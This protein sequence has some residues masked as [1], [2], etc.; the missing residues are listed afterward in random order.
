MKNCYIFLILLISLLTFTIKGVSVRDNM[1]D[2]GPKGKDADH[3]TPTTL[4]DG[5]KKVSIYP[6]AQYNF[7]KLYGSQWARQF[8]D[9]IFISGFTPYG[10]EN[11]IILK[12]LPN[13][14]TN[15]NAA[16]FPLRASGKLKTSGDV[17]DKNPFWKI[18]LTDNHTVEITSL[19]TVKNLI[20][21]KNARY[22]GLSKWRKTEKTNQESY[23]CGEKGA[24]IIVKCSPESETG[25]FPL[26]LFLNGKKIYEK[27]LSGGTHTIKLENKITGDIGKYKLKAKWRNAKCEREDYWFL[28]KWGTRL[29]IEGEEFDL[30]KFLDEYQFFEKTTFILERFDMLPSAIKNLKPNN[31]KLNLGKEK[32]LAQNVWCDHD[33]PVHDHEKSNEKRLCEYAFSTL[34]YKGSALI[35]Y[36][37]NYDLASFTAG[38]FLSKIPFLEQLSNKVKLI[39]NYDIIGELND[40]IAEEIKKESGLDTTGQVT[41]GGNAFVKH[42]EHLYYYPC[43]KFE[44]FLVNNQENK[45]FTGRIYVK[46]K[47]KVVV[48]VNLS[49]FW[50]KTFNNKTY[51]QWLMTAASQ[52]N[53]TNVEIPLILKGKIILYL[54]PYWKGS[55]IYNKTEVDENGRPVYILTNN[56]SAGILGKLGGILTFSYQPYKYQNDW[57]KQTKVTVIKY[58]YL[59]NEM[60]ITANK[61]WEEIE[62]E[63]ILPKIPKI[64]K[65][66]YN[67]E[68]VYCKKGR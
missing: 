5:I 24:E 11:H 6:P 34:Q 41:Y 46:P 57:R 22:L 25:K 40:F 1:S 64:D 60:T 23:A 65:E 3:I 39:S 47:A 12:W 7:E 17:N 14:I 68:T 61:D 4:E 27:S 28:K 26:K 45:W 51:A 9:P 37:S 32:G 16:K 29:T 36:E 62:E 48:K 10:S 35:Q 53:I 54:K 15:P 44:P 52:L 55:G 58:A 43:Y 67:K 18:A 33:C 56:T 49:N 66:F 8:Q 31:W 13:L 50:K 38:I 21:P 59:N 42:I 20:D 2:P 63:T 19:D 30:S